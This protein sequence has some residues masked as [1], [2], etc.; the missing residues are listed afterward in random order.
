MGRCG[1][2][3]PTTSVSRASLLAELRRARGG[4]LDSPPI[5]GNWHADVGLVA[6]WAEDELQRPGHS[7]VRHRTRAFAAVSGVSTSRACWV[8]GKLMTVAQLI[9]IQGGS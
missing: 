2:T 1:W 3:D 5:E 7:P 9:G 6:G 4:T 8:C